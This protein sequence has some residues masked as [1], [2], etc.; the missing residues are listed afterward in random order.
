M[1]QG[2]VGVFLSHIFHLSPLTQ[3]QMDIG[4]VYIAQDF[5]FL[6]EQ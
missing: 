3:S 2:K 6:L 5:T 1:S 4:S